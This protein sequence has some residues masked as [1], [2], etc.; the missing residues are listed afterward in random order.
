MLYVIR[1]GQTDWNIQHRLQGRTDVPLNE[2]GR[3]AALLASGAIADVHFDV[4]FC[5]P[6]SRAHETAR[7][8][9]AGRSVPLLIDHRLQEMSFGTLEGKCAD[10]NPL[11]ETFFHQPQDYLPPEGGESFAELFARIGEFL[12]RQV[13]P[14]LSAGKDVLVVAHGAA[15]SAIICQMRGLPLSEFWSAGLANCHLIRVD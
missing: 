2:E 13:R 3:R 15:N 7:L 12:D 1:H 9:L 5:S 10:G 14:L 4:C 11:V 8:L 6:L